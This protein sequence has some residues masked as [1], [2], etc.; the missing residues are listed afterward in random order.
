MPR[1]GG[2]ADKLGNRYE[3]IWTISQ[4]LE[5]LSGQLNSLTVEP[6]DPQESRGIEFVAR[7]SAGSL[8]YHSVKR[9]R[10]QGEWSLSALC[11]IDTTGR[12]VL[13]DLFRKLAAD[14]TAHCRFVSSTG[15]NALRELTERAQR[16]ATLDE[17]E[18]DLRQSETLWGEYESRISRLEA[19]RAIAF[20]RLRRV[21]V[22]LVDEATLIRG[23]ER[24]IDLLLFRPDGSTFDAKNV[25]LILGDFVLERLG[26]TISNRDLL[27]CLRSDGIH[28]RDW[29]VDQT[30]QDRI[31]AAK[32]DYTRN[33]E[34]DLINHNRIIRDEAHSIATHLLG[35]DEPRT[36]LLT[37][38]AGYGKSCVL[39][40]VISQLS[41]NQLPSMVVRLDRHGGANSTRELGN[42]LDLPQSPAI[43]LQGAANGQPSVLIIDQLDA[44][45]HASG[46]SPQLW[47]V[48]DR[49]REEALGAPNMR[50]V[51]ACRTFDLDND[52]R[53]RSLA[54]NPAEVR[55]VNLGLLSEDTVANALTTAGFAIERLNA[56]QRQ[57]LRTPLHL[58]LFL[59]ATDRARPSFAGIGSL[60]DRFWE[61][62]Q[63]RAVEILREPS[64]WPDA[65]YALCDAF[66]QRQALSAPIVT[67]D[68]WPEALSALTSENVLV[69]EGTQLRFFHESFFDYAFS[70]RFCA[71]GQELVTW[72]YQSEQQLFRR[73]QV[74]QILSFLRDHEVER[75]IRELNNLVNGD[76]V[77]FHLKKMVFQWLRSLPN[78][79]DGEW[80]VLRPYMNNPEMVHHVTAV[81]N[82]SIGWF[83]LLLRNGTFTSWFNS[84][85]Q[86]LIQTGQLIV[87]LPEIRRVRSAEIAGILRTFRGRGQ[88]W[89]NRLRSFFNQPGAHYGQEMRELFLDLL[90]RGAFDSDDDEQSYAW[91]NGLSEAAT[92]MPSFVAEA[93]GCWLENR[94]AEWQSG[95]RTPEDRSRMTRR[96]YA[97]VIQPASDNNAHEFAQCVCPRIA[98][99]VQVAAD[100]R[101][102]GRDR[103]WPSRPTFLGFGIYDAIL[104]G[105]IRALG[106]LANAE[107]DEVNRLIA[108]WRNTQFETLAFVA[109]RSWC[110]N[111]Q[112]F[113]NDC[114]EFLIANRQ[115]LGLGYS[116]WSD[117]NGRAAIGRQAISLIVPHVS[118]ENKLRLESAAAE[119]REEWE[120][121]D[122]EFAGSTCHLLLEAFGESNLSEAGQ[123]R[124]HELRERFPNADRSLPT[125]FGDL[126]RLS[127]VGSPVLS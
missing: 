55:R 26:S 3:G 69:R 36:V 68:R 126:A 116:T 102:P 103:I 74:R 88:E 86:Q 111:P 105:L 62:R 35:S 2:E 51:L 85:D 78:P 43:V 12:S 8:E 75:Y 45:S 16:R 124:V 67:L 125:D 27:E 50:L 56:D 32:Q 4:L 94:I 97:R 119:Y 61:H 93:I 72:L 81:L 29:A 99:L 54:R 57:V 83:D 64:S 25:R 110:A 37:A 58:L 65:I 76:R 28:R 127:V 46:R 79:L 80:Q 123:R 21:I 112:R 5:M 122:P 73:S 120:R 33:V 31:N 109:M 106:R 87:W 95:G 96:E 98:R 20:D 108:D 60:F 77:R 91:W 52:H 89:D 10:A 41:E 17:F 118:P 23:V 30:I 101:R 9:Q 114:A 11:Q 66:S 53:L 117:G 15:A 48:F 38:P 34:L 42:Q 18:Q 115:W 7:T 19:N 70:R 82:G 44:L 104:D 40:Q 39:S 107:P 71:S 14:S 6:L 63:S 84:G 13:G 90:R 113:A 100:P 22:T 59:E 24:Q 92:E 49:L 121:D 1:T 47:D